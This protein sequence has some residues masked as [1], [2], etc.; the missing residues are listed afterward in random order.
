VQKAAMFEKNVALFEKN[1]ALFEK[2]DATF[3][4]QVATCSNKQ[5]DYTAKS[6]RKLY[7]SVHRG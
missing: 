3:G 1:V 5:F 6:S 4:K 2:N 7:K